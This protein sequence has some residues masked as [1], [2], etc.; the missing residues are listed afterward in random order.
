MQIYFTIVVRF[1]IASGLGLA[2][3]V[4][5]DLLPRL[6]SRRPE[7]DQQRLG[8]GLEMIVTMNGG[9]FLQGN[10]TENLRK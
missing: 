9:P 4:Q 10:F 7:Q 2:G 3:A 8:E 6:A 5:H 1:R